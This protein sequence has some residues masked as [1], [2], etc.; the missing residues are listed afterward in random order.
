VHDTSGYA[1]GVVFRVHVPPVQ[2]GRPAVE[3]GPAFF[4]DWSPGPEEVAMDNLFLAQVA[5]FSGLDESSLQDIFHRLKP[6]QVRPG[7]MLCREGDQAT[8]LFVLQRGSAEVVLGALGHVGAARPVA[9]LRRG[10]VIS[11]LALLT[12]EPRSATVV[13][14]LPTT[15]LELDRRIFCLSS[16]DSPS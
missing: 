9:R 10:D 6:R 13:A 7:D 5:M 14:R 3:D 2:S 1:S 15:V 16:N 11:A 12:A 4:P 8:S